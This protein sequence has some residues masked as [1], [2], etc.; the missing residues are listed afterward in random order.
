MFS[1][2]GD[3]L[4]IVRV[5]ELDINNNIYIFTKPSG[6]DTYLLE[7]HGTIMFISYLDII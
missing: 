3:R 6:I 7:K 2:R 4:I 1:T 5:G